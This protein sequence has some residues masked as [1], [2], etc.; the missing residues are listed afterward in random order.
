MRIAAP[1]FI[2]PAERLDNVQYLRGLVEEIELLYFCS[3]QPQDLPDEHE[4][5]QLALEP[6][7]Y[8]VHLP[9]DR[10]GTLTATW[11]ML[12]KFVDSLCPLKA[13]T[14][15]L[16]L[17]PQRDFFCQ[18]EA[19]AGTNKGII[20][21]E[22]GGD[23]AH[24]FDEAAALPVDF[25][26]DVGHMIHF[27]R[28]VEAV[29]TRHQERIIL[30]HLHGSDGRRDHRSLKWIDPGLLRTV[31]QFALERELTICLEI[32]QEEALRESIGLLRDL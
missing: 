19:F 20:S 29:L 8:N 22:N 4:V 3:R 31:K 5:V 32:F 28:D 11:P 9:Y 7:R 10:D 18:L 2:I 25:C 16:H 23:N 6:M 21:V 12:Q 27:R 15:T 14:H 30:L 24:L 17:Q 13:Q 1:S 26:V